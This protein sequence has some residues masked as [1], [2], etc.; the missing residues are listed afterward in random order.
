LHNL[1]PI[2]KGVIG[3][4][5]GKPLYWAFEAINPGEVSDLSLVRHPDLAFIAD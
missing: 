1:F 3:L 2:L 5:L 4:E